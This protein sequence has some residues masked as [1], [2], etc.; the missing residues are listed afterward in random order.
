MYII[1]LSLIFSLFSI[2]NINYSNF[3]SSFNVFSAFPSF[4]FFFVFCILSLC[5]VPPLLG[6]FAKLYIF[7]VLFSK[8]AYFNIF[9]F[10]LFNTKNVDLFFNDNYVIGMPWWDYWIPIISNKNSF[11][12]YHINI[13]IMQKLILNQQKYMTLNSRTFFAIT[14]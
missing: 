11:T 4:K 8:F 14:L 3:N 7:N 12:I 1:T 13:L 6:F 2:I 9:I 10:F 5:G